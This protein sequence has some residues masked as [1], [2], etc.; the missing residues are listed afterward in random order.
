MDLKTLL[1]W[2][3]IYNITFTVKSFLKVRF[4]GVKYTHVI[5]TLNGGSLEAPDL[6]P[7]TV[8]VALEAE[9]STDQFPLSQAQERV[10]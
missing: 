2:Q 9:R 8:A 5:V 1:L 10:E 4:S 7:P 6:P 3:N